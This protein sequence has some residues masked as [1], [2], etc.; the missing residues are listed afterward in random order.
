MAVA[1]LGDVAYAVLGTCGSLTLCFRALFARMRPAG[2]Q[3][4][5]QAPAV[6]V[7][8]AQQDAEQPIRRLTWLVARGHDRL[9]YAGLRHT[10]VAIGDS[11]LAGCAGQRSP[12]AVV[13][14]PRLQSV[15]NRFA[16]SNR[17]STAVP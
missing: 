1:D 11:A 13:R 12:R 15:A 2:V 9:V 8:P 4:F 17:G 5:E 6:L 3:A 14:R 16:C 7:R 10:V